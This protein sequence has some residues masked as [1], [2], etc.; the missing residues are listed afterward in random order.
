MPLITPV[1]GQSEKDFIRECM[2]DETMN[3]EFPDEKQR[4]AVC[5]KQYQGTDLDLPQ[6]RDSVMII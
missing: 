1:E 3:K 5:S 6:T 2:I 4:L